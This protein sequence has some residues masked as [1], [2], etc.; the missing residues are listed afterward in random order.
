MAVIS[1]KNNQID[2]GSL[3]LKVLE[4]G[5]GAKVGA[6]QTVTLTGV[7]ANAG[8]GPSSAGAS[9]GSAAAKVIAIDIGGV[10]YYIGA[11]SSNA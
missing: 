1:T 5:L 2:Q 4:L 11:W 9:G 6:A 8:T 7:V 3:Q 10:T